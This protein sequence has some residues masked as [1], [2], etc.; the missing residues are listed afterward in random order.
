MVDVGPVCDIDDGDHMLVVVDS[1]TDPVMPAARRP[2][3]LKRC[4]QW[5]PR[6]LRIIAK[7]LH[8][9][10]LGYQAMADAINLA[11]FQR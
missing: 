9:N 11:L 2:V 5:L 6:A 4:H 7:G 10:D 1:I 8:P 3:A